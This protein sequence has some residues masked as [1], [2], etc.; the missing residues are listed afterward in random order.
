MKIGSLILLLLLISPTTGVADSQLDLQLG[1]QYYKLG[2]EKSSDWSN[3]SLPLT[4]KADF[5]SKMSDLHRLKLSPQF[6]ADPVTMES[7]ER[8]QF[9]WNDSYYEL[10]FSNSKIRMGYQNVVWEGT[11]FSNPLDVMM[12]KN[13]TDPLDST[14]ISS[15]GISFLHEYQNMQFDF[16]FIPQMT[17]SHLPGSKNPWWPR[18]NGLHLETS[19]YILLVPQSVQYQVD[20]PHEINHAR[21]NNWG[22][23]IQVKTDLLD[24][25]IVYFNGL[26]NSPYVLLD[27]N[28]TL[29]SLNPLTLMMESPIHLRPLL[30]RTQ[31]IGGLVTI[32]IKESLIRIAGNAVI[33][34]KDDPR[35]PGYSAAQVI[36]W[37]KTFDLKRGPL[38]ALLQYHQNQSP[39][40]GQL[41]FLQSIFTKALSAGIRQSINDE[42]SLLLGHIHDLKGHSNLTRVELNRRL[43]DQLEMGIFAL[44]L[45]GSSNTLLGI[46]ESYDRYG[47]KLTAYY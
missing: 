16:H 5:K 8:S 9:T 37:E 19:E 46:Y 47:I 26:S 7:T 25:S 2:I 36:G 33:P 35:V 40:D 6:R 34:Q 44:N 31:S 42:T 38:T 29:V 39:Q 10:N 43:T 12:Q 15:P 28:T 30:Y 23:R 4:I 24:T 32:P 45:Q 27:L 22:G 20:S 3:Q 18:K 14:P 13:L 11:D 17:P 21:S 1:L 41:S